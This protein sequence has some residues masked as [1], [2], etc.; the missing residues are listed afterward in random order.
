MLLEFLPSFVLG[1]EGSGH[2]TAEDDF[3]G[4]ISDGDHGLT[5]CFTFNM[6][7]AAFGCN[8]TGPPCDFTFSGLHYDVATG[9]TTKVASQVVSIPACPAL[10]RCQLAPIVLDD[11]FVDLNAIQIKA[12]TAGTP[13]GWWMDNL[14]LGWFNNSCN[15]GLC[16]Q[17][18]HIRK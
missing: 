18:A 8:S 6:Y 4:Q 2:N 1:I 11:T 13:L 3:S 5:G 14:Q 7:G 15:T 17:S 12:A 16:R 9:T 10:T